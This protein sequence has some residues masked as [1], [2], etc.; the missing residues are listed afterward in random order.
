MPRS[1][2]SPD[3]A[4]TAARA[5]RSTPRA[6][7]ASPPVARRRT[8]GTS[9]PSRSPVRAAERDR[10]RLVRA[11][12]E[13]DDV[14]VKRPA[15]REE[16]AHVRLL[17][18]RDHP[19]AAARARGADREADERPAERAVAERGQDGEA[20][21]LPEPPAVVVRIQPHGPADDAVLGADGVQRRAVAVAVVAVVARA[22]HSLL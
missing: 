17:D 16:E 5:A 11:A 10:H 19:L 14:A 7:C 6:S 9:P 12:V 1:S 18:H 2:A 13:V 8:C 3:A 22:E 20:V 21:A 4:W 15:E